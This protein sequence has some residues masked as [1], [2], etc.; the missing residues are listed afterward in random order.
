MEGAAEVAL[1]HIEVGG[2][3]PDI[4]SGQPL[5][6]FEGESF[7]IA[8]LVR[9]GETIGDRHLDES[10]RISHI[11]RAKKSI[12]EPSCRSGAP[13]IFQRDNPL[14]NGRGR[15]AEHRLRRSQVKT[16]HDGSMPTAAE[17]SMHL[18]AGTQCVHVDTVE[19]G[20]P[21]PNDELRFRTRNRH[22]RH[23]DVA[24]D[25]EQ[26]PHDGRRRGA[27]DAIATDG[28]CAHMTRFSLYARRPRKVGG[29]LSVSSNTL[30]EPTV[31]LHT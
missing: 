17:L 30:R 16:R 6:G 13:Q 28:V 25:H 5:G 20:R 29:A 3:G 10:S 26:R 7:A 19:R 27:R 21:E 24:L 1:A 18:A 11:A 23:V 14:G 4:R 12:G 31:T 15:R 22:D 2:D 8:A 9:N